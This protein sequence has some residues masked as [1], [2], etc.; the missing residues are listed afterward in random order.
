MI[1]CKN[2]VG[3]LEY[4]KSERSDEFLL[5]FDSCSLDHEKNLTFEKYLND[6]NEN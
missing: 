2:K 6:S 5:T 4:N 1:T 3:R